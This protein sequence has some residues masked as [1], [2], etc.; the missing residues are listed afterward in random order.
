MTKYS[1]FALR[2]ILALGISAI[3]NMA[4][5]QK[6]QMG[7]VVGLA[8]LFFALAYVFEYLR[9]IGKNDNDGSNPGKS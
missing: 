2:L 4:F 8:V 5:F 3:V 6:L 7:K 1:V 9:K